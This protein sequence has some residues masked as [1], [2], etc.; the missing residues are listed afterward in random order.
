[1]SWPA[2]GKDRRVSSSLVDTE[3]GRPRALAPLHWIA[4][5]LTRLGYVHGCFGVVAEGAHGSTRRTL[6]SSGSS[7]S[8]LVTLD[9]ARRAAE[10]LAQS[11]GDTHE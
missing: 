8:A 5:P 9:N 3:R 11:S 7:S 10:A 2:G 4:V 6:A 1:M